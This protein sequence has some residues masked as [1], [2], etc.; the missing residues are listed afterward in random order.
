MLGD[1]THTYFLPFNLRKQNKTTYRCKILSNGTHLHMGQLPG[2]AP[3]SFTL[4]YTEE[5]NENRSI[6]Q[7]DFEFGIKAST[8]FDYL[9]YGILILT[10]IYQVCWYT[11]FKV[12]EV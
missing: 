11:E 7:N 1:A 10:L 9:V 5:I 6:N 2:Y 12:L 3:L 8:I 4:L